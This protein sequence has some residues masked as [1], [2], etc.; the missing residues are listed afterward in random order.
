MSKPVEQHTTLSAQ[1]DTMGPD[2]NGAAAMKQISVGQEEKPQT[3]SIK[4]SDLDMVMSECLLS[5]QEAMKLIQETNGD[6]EKALRKWIGGP[7]WE[8]GK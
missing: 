3:I 7:L 2:P 6:V 4:R 1:P 5:Q 8:E